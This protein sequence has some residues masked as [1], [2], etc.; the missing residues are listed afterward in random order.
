MVQKSLYTSL[1][2]NLNQMHEQPTREENLLYLVFT[3][4]QSLLKSSVNTPGTSDHD[5]ILADQITK[6]HYIAQ[7]P[8]KKYMFGQANWEE[9]KTGQNDTYSTV[10]DQYNN[11]PEVEPLWKTLKD[12]IF[13]FLDQRVP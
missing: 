5:I 9:I 12:N 4:T 11:L 3:T 1:R 8:R 10:K 2:Y 6:P 13:K 7:E